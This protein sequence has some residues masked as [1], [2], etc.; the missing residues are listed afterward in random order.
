[1][2]FMVIS[3]FIK[4]LMTLDWRDGQYG[5]YFFSRFI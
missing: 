2:D 5:I 4:F 3:Y 1:M